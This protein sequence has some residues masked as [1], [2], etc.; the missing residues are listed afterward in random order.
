MSGEQHLEPKQSQGGLF[1]ADGNVSK[2]II[3]PN[4]SFE[5]KKEKEVMTEKK[6]ETK[7]QSQAPAQAKEVSRQSMGLDT[8]KKMSVTQLVKQAPKD[9]FIFALVGPNPEKAELAEAEKMFARE[10]SYALRAFQ[11]NDFLRKTAENNK[12]SVINAMIDLG[13]SGLTLSPVLKLGYLVP[14]DKKV[15]FWASYM[16]KREIVM[17]SGQVI[18]TYARLVYEGDKFEV[19]YGSGGYLKHEADPFSTK[20]PSKVKGGYWYCRLVNGAEKFGTMNKEEIEAIQKRSPSANASFSP[21][22]SDWEE[23]AKKTIFNRGFKEMPKSGLSADQIRALEIG[24][25]YEEKEMAQWVAK[26]RVKQDSF[27]EDEPDEDYAD[28]ETID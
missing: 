17:K 5:T 3:K 2:D 15:L 28:V 6:E 9:K 19:K 10:A 27:D 14:M 4:K 11:E 24:D 13:H 7:M 12:L 18:D 23:M 1:D 25:Q 26:T 22:K 16:G 8:I 21:W 20:D